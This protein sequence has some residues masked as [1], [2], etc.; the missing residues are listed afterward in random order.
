M[1]THT[2]SCRQIVGGV[3]E[4]PALV[5][6]TR[7]S[8]W[9]G[10]DPAS[11][12][13]VE[14]GNPFEGVNIAGKVLVFRSTKGS[15]GTS[16]ML[17][18]AKMAGHAP[19]AFIN[20]ELD[21]L[22]TLACV[23]LGLP[24]VTELDVD[25]FVAMQTGDIVRVDADRGVVEVTSDRPAAPRCEAVSNAPART[26]ID[27]TPEQQA[28]L[29]GARGDSRAEHLRL[30]VEWGEAV[31]AERLIEVDNVLPGG[32]FV[33]NRTL[34][35]LPF[36]L[37][38]GYINYTK[39]CLIDDV[40]GV[41]ATAHAS[42]MDLE[43]LEQ[44]QPDLRQVPAQRELLDLGRKAGVSMTWTCAPYLVGNVPISGQV[45][46]WTESHAVVFV[47]S[48]L[49]ARTTRNGNE[50]AAA[51]MATGF[52]PEFGVLRSE[53]RGADFVIEVDVELTSD[54]DWGCL[55]YFAGKVGGLRI[56]AFTGL[57]S[58]RIE[59][60]R[61]LCAALA[62][63]G[64]APMLHIVGVTPEAP[65]LAAALKDREPDETLTFG[66][67]E[68]AAVYDT[69][70]TATDDEVDLVY[71]GCPHATLQE[72]VELAKELRGKQVREGVT[73]LVSMSYAIEAQARRLGYAQEIEDAGGRVMTDSC[74]SNAL[75]REST[76]M[77]TPAVKTGSYAP[78]LLQCEVILAPMPECVRIAE[79]G[80]RSRSAASVV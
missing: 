54:A 33:P 45:C 19:L 70:S 44:F 32:L 55:G 62:T 69:L 25:P 53:G 72:V 8:F 24:L 79:T 35:E 11:G 50:S 43:R 20:T 56:P 76:R 36:E 37:I 63:S 28:M 3:A 6:D 14:V 48:F 21:E 49:A 4:G 40:G 60:A 80:R 57:P 10:F 67:D 18:L 47:N 59:S 38:E 29:D 34:G 7:I 66:A 1:P 61:Q 23:A 65:T 78:N 31:G 58:P 42:F 15:S 52:V 77:A 5:A 26:T 68:L 71:F 64:G 13:I 46:A 22:S 39:G 17:R 30:L 2:Y 27:L 73:L 41:T 74:P 12:E 16:L 51:A 75:W 9:G